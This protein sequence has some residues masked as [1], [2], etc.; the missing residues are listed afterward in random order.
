M[1]N[2]TEFLTAA[3]SLDKLLT[4]EILWSLF[5]KFDI[6][7]SGDITSE[8]LRVALNRMGR[9]AV[10]KNEVQKII[11]THSNKDGRITFEN[12]KAI[13]AQQGDE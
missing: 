6:D 7:D 10:Q 9:T 11:A 4:D 3:T 5:K 13:F 1:I 8:D 2:Y 12:F